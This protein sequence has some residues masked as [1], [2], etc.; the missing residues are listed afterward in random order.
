VTA[1]AEVRVDARDELLVAEA[2]A[3]MFIQDSEQFD[4]D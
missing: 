1:R 2:D 4:H 3:T